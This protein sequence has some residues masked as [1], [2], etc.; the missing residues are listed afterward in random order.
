MSVTRCARDPIRRRSSRGQALPEFALVVPVLALILLAIIQFAFIFA[1]Q[2]GITNAVR[3]GARLA[4]VTTPTTTVGQ[5]TANGNGVYAALTNTTN[6]FLR[7]NVF[8]YG[9]GNLVESGTP[10]TQV[11]YE[12]Y[13]DSSGKFAV[14]VRVEAYYRHPIFL[15]LVGIILD[16]MDGVSDNALRVGA[17]EE[18]RVENEELL[19]TYAGLGLTCAS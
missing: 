6:G 8:A 11:C 17:S 14:E 2:V 3:E 13:T 9:P 12:S 19:S 16:R 5:A 7:R 1:S 18:M 10:E 4:A 15:P